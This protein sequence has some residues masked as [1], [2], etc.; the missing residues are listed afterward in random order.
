[1]VV[2]AAGHVE[3]TGSVALARSTLGAWRSRRR[4]CTSDCRTAV[5][6]CSTRRC[7]VTRARRRAW[8]TSGAVGSGCRPAR[9]S[10]CSTP[11]WRCV[12]TTATGACVARTSRARGPASAGG[13]SRTGTRSCSATTCWRAVTP[14]GIALMVDQ[15]P[16]CAVHVV[17]TVGVSR[18]AG[19]DVPGR[20]RPDLGR[21][22]L[23]GG[24][25]PA[26][27]PALVQVAPDRPSEAW[28]AF[29]SVLGIDTRGLQLPTGPVPA[30]DPAPSGGGR[31]PA[32]GASATAR[33][34]RRRSAR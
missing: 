18:P 8:S 28:H 23:V 19:G 11:R 29:G 20:L 25:E 34:P 17:V 3:F 13:R 5:V 15:L 10:R 14:D 32:H 16:G 7:G 9:R 1:M 24:R 27:A 31:R 22:A 6:T 12:A 4:S 33:R 21:P 2:T 26:R 30:T